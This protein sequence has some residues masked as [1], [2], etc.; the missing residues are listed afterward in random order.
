MQIKKC[1]FLKQL[2]SKSTKPSSIY[3]NK[4]TTHH[5]PGKFIQIKRKVETT[6]N[7]KCRKLKKFFEKGG[8]E[9][10]NNIIYVW[11]GS[12]LIWKVY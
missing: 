2:F 5:Y 1:F 6:V 7:T 12:I 8:I 3:S 11:Y 9:A 10:V 4:K